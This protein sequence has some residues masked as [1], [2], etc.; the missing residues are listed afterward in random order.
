[1]NRTSTDTRRQGFRTSSPQAFDARAFRLAVGPGFQ[2][3]AVTSGLTRLISR[4]R[5]R[6]IGGPIT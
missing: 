1:M 5:G 4:E 3:S 2:L 6:G